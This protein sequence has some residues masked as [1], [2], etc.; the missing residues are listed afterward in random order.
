MATNRA[1]RKLLG[2]EDPYDPEAT[3]VSQ[4]AQNMRPTGRN[5]EHEQ[6]VAALRDSNVNTSGGMQGAVGTY[7][8]LGALN[9]GRAGNLVLNSSNP[10]MT[11]EQAAGMGFKPTYTSAIPQADTSSFKPKMTPEQAQQVLNASGQGTAP[12]AANAMPNS[13]EAMS[14]GGGPVNPTVAS[15]GRRAILGIQSTEQANDIELRRRYATGSNPGE[16]LADFKTRLSDIQ[17]A[18]AAETQTRFLPRT[19]TPQVV[20]ASRQAS[21]E[22]FGGYRHGGAQRRYGESIRLEDPASVMARQKLLDIRRDAGTYA[23]QRDLRMGREQQATMLAAQTEAAKAPGLA[24]VEAAKLSSE[25]AKAVAGTNAAAREKE[26]TIKAQ[27]DVDAAK[28]MAGKPATPK[29]A[30]VKP[31]DDT[32]FNADL[33]GVD[34]ELDALRKQQSYLKPGDTNFDDM[35]SRFDSKIDELRAKRKEIID[36]R[37]GRGVGANVTL[38]PPTAPVIQAPPQAPAGSLQLQTGGTVNGGAPSL[39]TAATLPQQAPVAPPQPQVP[40]AAPVAAPQ[41]VAQPIAPD[42]LEGK[43]ATNAN[44]QKIKRVNG[45]WIPIQ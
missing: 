34:D 41:P 10:M 28:A 27:G 33:K 12:T 20:E 15:A 3:G 31:P 7:G 9:T 44:G 42:P 26:A 24:K 17:A 30:P 39:N 2:L 32:A 6:A 18:R 11:A 4:V 22:V 23:G 8:R 43:T 37:A 35:N 1:R 16:S 14:L 29:P 25:T 45:Q 5:D 36:R 40:Q 13:V 38:N 21:G 19:V